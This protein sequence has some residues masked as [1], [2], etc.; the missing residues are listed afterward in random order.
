MENNSYVDQI[1]QLSN[2]NKSKTIDMKNIALILTAAFLAIFQTSCMKQASKEK[3][4]VVGYNFIRYSIYNPH[5]KNYFEDNAEKFVKLL[6]NSKLYEL[7]SVTRFGIRTKCFMPFNLE[8]EEANKKFF[9]VFY[10]DSVPEIFGG[11]QKDFQV[12]IQVQDGEFNVKTCVGPVKPNEVNKY[13]NFKLDQFSKVGV[14]IDIDCVMEKKIN[15]KASRAL[16]D[17]AMT[18]TWNKIGVLLDSI[19]V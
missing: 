18:S 14:Y 12:V 8:F 19:G 10:K 13:F 2:L 9:N 1:V 3:D 6:H 17:K 4:A 7:P 16:I 15:Y 5:T 11:V